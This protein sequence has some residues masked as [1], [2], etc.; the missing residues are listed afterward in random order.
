MPAREHRA[1]LY[2]PTTPNAPTGVFDG[3]TALTTLDLASNNLSTLA[4]DVFDELTALETLDINLNELTTLPAGVF[5]NLTALTTLDMND[6]DLSTL[7]A[8]VFEKL[9]AL[10]VL[11]LAGNEL[12]T[13]SVDLFDDL[14]ALDI[15]W[16]NDNAL[17]TLPADV[18]DGLTVMTDLDLSGN[19]LAT[20]PSAVFDDTTALILLKV[21]D[22][23]ITTL[24]ADM[25]DG[26]TVMTDLDL[27]GNTLATLPD[28]IFQPLTALFGQSAL[29]LSD[30]P[31]APFGP[32][33]V[34]LPDD[35]I[36]PTA[37][38]TV[39]LDG[40]GSDGGPWGTNV[41]YLWTLTIPD[42]GVTVT[43]NDDTS[44][45][46]VVTIPALTEGTELT[47]TLTVSPRDGTAGIAPATDTAKVTATDSTTVSISDD[48][49]TAVFR[50]DSITYTLTRT[51]STTAALPVSVILTQT[52]NFLATTELT[53]TVTIPAGQTTETFTVAASSFQHFATG[54]AV[55]AGTLTAAVQDGTDYDLGTPPSVAVNIVIGAM[56]RIEHASYSVNEVDGSLLV[57]LIARTGPGAPQPTTATSTV[58]IVFEDVTATQGTDFS[59]IAGN[60]FIF[61]A[62][63]FSMVSG[64]WQAEETYYI[65][66]TNDD[67]D[68]D[69]ETFLLKLK[70]H[71]GSGDDPLVD[72][73]GNACDSVDGCSVTVTIVD[74]DTAGVSVSK[75]AITITE[76]DT[77]G[78][79]YTVVLDS[80]PTANVTITIGGQSAADITATPT[81]LTFTTTNWA[82]AQTVTVTAA[83]DTDTV[84]DTHS[85]THSAVSS[86]TDYSGISI[87]SV[88]V[89]VNDDDS[90][91]NA[92]TGKPGITGAAQVGM[93]LTAGTA[94]IVDPD[95]L[96][97]PGY[98]YQW[99]KAGNDIS[100]A[101]NSTYTLTSSDY[102][103]TIQ[104]KVDF[105]DDQNNAESLTSD[106][107]VPVAPVA[108]TCPTDTGT[109]WCA[110]LTVGHPLDADGD[111]SGSVFES[112]S[113]RTAFGS[114]S[115]AT[116]RHL[117]VDYT[118][119]TVRGGAIHDLVLATTPH[120]PLDGAGLTLHVQKYAGELDLPLAEAS[121]D[122]SS[123]WLFGGV[124][125]ANP[126]DPLS[127]VPLIRTLKS[128]STRVPDPPD[129]GTEVMVRL[130]QTNAA[131]TFSMSTESRNVA[132]NTAPGQNV[133]G[134]FTAT[135]D[136]GDTLTY[137]LEG[138]DAASFNLIAAGGV[139]QLRTKPGVTYNYE[140]K[141]AYT[142]VIK[143][144]D[145][146]GGTA[147]VTVTIT[148]TDVNE[149]PERPAVPSVSGASGSTTSLT[150]N[151]N[152]PDN[153]GPNID[154]YDLQYRQG[155]S[156][157]FTNGPQNVTGTST[158]IPNLAANTSYQVQVRAT[159]AEGIARG[160]HQ[161]PARPAR[162]R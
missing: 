137:T 24:P 56:I 71:G 41:T 82:T 39:T 8:D 97:T 151:W 54:T 143:A 95:G 153:T 60:S 101:T 154:N 72:T 121:F 14:T 89:T 126:S 86:D 47:Y 139:A 7:S 53:E 141:A 75:S 33:A 103:E 129:I 108:A 88:D 30:N 69:D 18:F 93:T 152:A 37:G 23:Q 65:S 155:N 57:K 96:A 111:P 58:V 106:E 80:Q 110:T 64:A 148:V 162:P 87:D 138:T 51:G 78:D 161:G 135:D 17:T 144:D 42:T 31:G 120:L 124:L 45:T 20:L 36:I 15:L 127:D 157:N 149:P 28:D 38:D 68:E 27:S 145:S 112:R 84:T 134:T 91:N 114:L 117:G 73:S 102:G 128:N 123:Y 49:T 55:E 67:I 104:V 62:S 118:V 156:G 4:A 22:N 119:T 21:A 6:N 59:S 13:L 116:F 46:T 5:D 150:V 92:P 136:D 109:V 35:A 77:T 81:P 125:F 142:V 98:T 19:A 99:L 48:K 132:E 146:N 131:P 40:S 107:T 50:E 133:G 61:A 29:D 43:F 52:K 9:T 12:S 10:T 66:L 140:V 44:A 11:D 3:L 122:N 113:G 63:N 160:L 130:S 105:T 94:D 26:L 25:F 76:E 34:A 115:G 147:I 79:T 90:T 32:T 83:N 100:G 158:T 159:N 16:L 70:Y 2:T 85:L 1:V 74:D